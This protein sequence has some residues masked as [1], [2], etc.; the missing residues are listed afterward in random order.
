MRERA[1]V[2][3]ML[4]ASRAGSRVAPEREWTCECGQGYR[5]AGEGRHRVYWRGDAA[6][7]DPVIDGTC[8]SCERALPAEPHAATH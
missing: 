1:L 7:N 6:V 3:Q 8:V 4:G 2:G 5:I